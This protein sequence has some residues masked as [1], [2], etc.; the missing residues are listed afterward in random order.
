MQGLHQ[1]TCFLEIPGSI[2]W[3]NLIFIPLESIDRAKFRYQNYIQ[4][5]RNKI[6]IYDYIQGYLGFFYLESPP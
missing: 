3:G 5:G 4:R 6:Y 1:H 2:L